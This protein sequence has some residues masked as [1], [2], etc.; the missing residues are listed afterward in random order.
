MKSDQYNA[1]NFLMESAFMCSLESFVVCQSFFAETVAKTRNFT[2]YKS[3]ILQII[4]VP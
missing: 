3:A 4:L 2:K 1:D